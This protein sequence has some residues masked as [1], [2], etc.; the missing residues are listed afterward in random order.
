MTA[1]QIESKLNEELGEL[2]SV[3]ARVCARVCARGA[4]L[5]IR[6]MLPSPLGV[7]LPFADGRSHVCQKM[8]THAHISDVTLHRRKLYIGRAD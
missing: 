8:I 1:E 4:W 6:L 3:R 7:S 5:V 2:C